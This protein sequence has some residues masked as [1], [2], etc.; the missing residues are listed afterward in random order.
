MKLDLSVRQTEAWGIPLKQG[1]RIFCSESPEHVF[2]V[3][4]GNAENRMPSNVRVAW[5]A[6]ECVQKCE[7]QGEH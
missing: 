2:A 6:S 7:P 5:E 3:N 4:R 1:T